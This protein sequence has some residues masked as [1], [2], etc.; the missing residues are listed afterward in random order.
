MLEK[1]LVGFLSG[2][3]Y[4]DLPPAVVDATRRET[5]WTLGTSV[6]GSGADGS[7]LI[8]EFAADI[9]GSPQATV[10]GRGDRLPASVAGFVNGCFAKALEY[11]DKLW[12][13]DGHGY[14]IGTSVVPAALAVAELIGGWCAPC[15]ACWRAAGTAPTSSARSAP[16]WRPGD[17]SA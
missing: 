13:D 12:I 16:P 11:E 2:V 1:E 4:D 9:G 14:A 15:T 17:C 10:W 8:R 5:L 3:S 7:D 6:A